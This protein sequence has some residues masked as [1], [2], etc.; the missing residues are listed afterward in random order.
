M[1][2]SLCNCSIITIILLFSR[3]SY[4]VVPF[5]T[6]RSQGF[7]AVREL[8]GWQTQIN[9]PEMCTIYGSFSVTPE[10]CRSFRS[11]DIA[12]YLFGD[13]LVALGNKNDLCPM[14][15]VQGTKVANRDER[16]LM[17]EN[18]Y[19]PT[20]FKSEVSVA[21]RVDNLVVDF[22][23]YLGMDEW[24][25]GSFFRIHMPI[26]YTRWNLNLNEHVID[27]G[28][29]NYDPGYF[30]S[31]YVG[32]TVPPFE[33]AQA[34]GIKRGSLL[35][36]FAEYVYD[37]QT[38]EDVKGLTFASL[39]RARMSP[40]Q[41]TKT[42]IAELTAALGWNFI[43][44]PDYTLGIEARTAAPTGNRPEGYWLFEPIAGNGLHWEFG[45]GLD[46][47][48]RIWQSC[49]ECHD[50]TCYCDAN[51]THL[52]PARQC[53]TFDLKNKPLSR[54]MLALAF[55]N[56]AVDLVA[57]DHQ[58]R[59][60]FNGTVMPVANF[61]TMPIDVTIAAQA[62]IVL[63]C[64]YRYCN[65]Q[66][67]LGYNFWGRSCEALCRRCD[68]CCDNGFQENTYGLKGDSFI[69]GFP[70]TYDG[71]G[72][73]TGLGAAVALGPTQ[74]KATIYRGTNNYPDGAGGVAWNQNPGIDNAKNAFDN[75]FVP[76][77]LVTHM[78]GTT[79]PVNFGWTQVK[80]SFDPILITTADIDTDG[81]RTG[82]ISNKIFGAITYI[83]HEC[84]T[85]TPY[86]S[87]GASVEFGMKSGNREKKSLIDDC[88]AVCSLSQSS[89]W[90][91]GGIS[92]N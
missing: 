15:L 56:N 55:N 63:D 38:I 73:L 62:D 74:S 44:C 71:A 76:H 33:D 50:V 24:L 85:W 84:G 12:Q 35:E 65:W 90:F 19:L 83:G 52:F 81:A 78:I 53:R 77:E 6:F 40:C 42:S 30:N 51:I 43:N 45:F 16:A 37:S 41:L 67:D 47:R 32:T 89:I 80:T 39:E 27:P 54:Y 11:R 92:F 20:D 86:C 88:C 26:V 91:K 5:L 66:F 31:T 59:Y 49:D 29:N 25:D 17:A 22:N 2:K 75:A 69:Y 68:C 60:Q 21:P 13:A 28:V 57:G 3:T 34:Y 72:V 23:F 8:A 10:Y 1:N 4:A 58:S 46:A 18:F 70:A 82:G 79:N 9:K 64:V 36:S 87:L 61:S 7:N 48:A 14:F